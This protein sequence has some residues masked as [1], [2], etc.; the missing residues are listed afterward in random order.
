M[1]DPEQPPA[2][3]GPWPTWFE[4]ATKYVPA[5]TAFCLVTAFA[6]DSLFWMMVDSR[7]LS[8]FGLSDHIETAV[9]VMTVFLATSAIVL[10][11]LYLFT[12]PRL[13]RRK[14][15]SFVSNLVFLVIGVTGSG[16]ILLGLLFGLPPGPRLAQIAVITLILMMVS[17]FGVPLLLGPRT[18]RLVAALASW[19][20][21]HAKP[22]RLLAIW[23]LIILGTAF[24]QSL[25]VHE[26]GRPGKD[27][28]E[29]SDERYIDGRIIRVLD[30]GVVMLVGD[31][32]AIRFIPKDRITRIGFRPRICGAD[33]FECQQ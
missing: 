1:T 31:Y 13:H 22:V 6:Y 12:R 15:R 2:L 9:N 17:V 24:Y 32:P 33:P 27:R 4:I 7:V 14:P 18:P 25:L 11:Y 16:G 3:P 10:V 21:N 29:L 26:Q 28:V 20:E 8:L 19:R 23:V 30:K 5:M